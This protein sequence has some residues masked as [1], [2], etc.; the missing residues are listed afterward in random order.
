MRS[1]W[2]S[3]STLALLLAMQLRIARAGNATPIVETLASSVDSNHDTI[4]LKVQL[5]GDAISAYSLVGSASHPLELPPAFQTK[6]P[7]GSSIGGVDPMFFQFKK[8]AAFDS[9]VTIGI[10][11]GDSQSALSAVGLTKDFQD[12]SET[13]GVHNK[14]C[15]VFFMDPSKGP[16][17]KAGPIVI[18]QLT[19]KKGANTKARIGIQGKK[20]GSGTWRH[21]GIVFA[22]GS[23]APPPP[24][25]PAPGGHGGGHSGHAADCAGVLGGSATTDKCGTC[26]ADPLNDCK[27]DC[28]G[29]WGG[30]KVNDACGVCGG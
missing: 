28:A 19:V 13:K 26:D 6:S 17:Q 9:W 7:V 8:E 24:T 10:T 5:T 20:R 27:Q 1:W 11:D 30:N 4:R 29:Q 25:P 21:D 23:S 2:C 22:I 15:G 3:S 16:T 14:N 18:A 12:W